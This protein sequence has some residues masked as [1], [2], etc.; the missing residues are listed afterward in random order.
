MLV[1]I[2]PYLGEG[3]LGVAYVLAYGMVAHEAERLGFDVFSLRGAFRRRGFHRLREADLIHPN[4]AGHAVIASE[5]EEFLGDR[6]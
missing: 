4:E 2:I 1:T 3:A 5:L 6:W